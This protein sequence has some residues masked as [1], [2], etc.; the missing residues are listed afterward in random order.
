MG[1]LRAAAEAALM[2]SI[3]ARGSAAEAVS[4][5]LHLKDERGRQDEYYSSEGAGQWFGAGA[6]ALGI[7]GEITPEAFALAA[8]GRSPDGENLV[9]GAGDKHRAG[10]D[11]TLSAPKSVSVLWGI[12]DASR[13]TEIQA[14]HGQ[15]VERALQHIEQ[16]FTLARRGKGGVEREQAKLLWSV[17][18]HGTSREQDPQLHSHA[19][20]HNLAQRADGTWGGIDPRELYQWKLALGA[21][22]RAG[23]A[24]SMR[25]LGYKIE[26]DGD[27]FRVSGVP[28]EVCRQF[29]KRREQIEAA[30]AEAGQSSAKSSE[31]AALGTRQAKSRDL[32]LD[33]LHARWQD[34]ASALH[35]SA[36]QALEVETKDDLGPMPAPEELL[37]RATEHD[38]VIEDRHI[39]QAV[40]VA[41]QHR[42]MGLDAIRTHVEDVLASDACM[43]LVH[44]E[45]GDVRY[46][47]RELYRQERQIISAAQERAE[48]DH[49]AVP[50][51]LVDQA[52][53][54]FSTEKGFALSAEQQTAVRHVTQRDGAVQ[55][56]VGDAGTGKSTAMLAAR[57][58]WESAGQR[59]IGCAISGKAAAGL[60]EGSGIES[61]TIASLLIT[62]EPTTD[63]QTGEVRAPRDAL[64]S[65]DVLVIDEAGMVDSRTMHRLMEHVNAACC[66]VVMAGDHKQL[67]SVGAGGV[68]RHLAERDSARI[69]E[70]HRQ[71][72]GWARDAVR[73]FSRGDAAEAI[74]R[75][76]DRDLV[77]VADDQQTAITQAVDRWAA[78]AAEVGASE[79]LLMAS[80]NAEVAA[81]NT[82]ARARMQAEHRLCNEIEIQVHDRQGR[83]AGK[84]AVA[85]GDRLLAKKNDRATSLKNGDLMTVER[86]EYTP[87][88]VQVIARLDRT[89]ELVRFDPAEYSQLRHGYAVTT[90]AAQGATVDRAVALAGGSMTSRESTYVQMSRMRE[91]AEIIA[92]RQQLRDAAEQIGP[93]EKM[94]E[95]AATVVAE[96]ATDLPPECADSFSECRAWLND[97]ARNELGGVEVDRLAELKDLIEAMGASRQKETTLDYQIAVDR[98]AEQ[99]AEAPTHAAEPV[100]PEPHQAHEHHM[101]MEME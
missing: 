64:S 25:E 89:A 82:A 28:H 1:S 84:L 6:E 22:Y 54:Q 59:V 16:E 98:E 61:R 58:A 68:F 71:R 73:E 65:T 34:E 86:I 15:A 101:T 30:L 35:F 36:D 46:T 13:Q 50:A 97:H 70:I 55:V 66:R 53:E 83:S 88:G 11:L 29:S 39:W 33:E 79:A 67:Q 10:W 96:Q 41:A 76:L 45:T 19:F 14:A 56:I 60:Q 49:H 17:F 8:A 69:T 24:S 37:R 90:H 80:T 20:L 27:S 48:E 99:H 43:R 94:L 44:P 21:T 93:T 9:Q 77:H 32:N 3:S 91:T 62:L 38:A 18:Q 7:A 4:Y 2:L 57:M 100:Q 81:L 42:G 92:T 63:P 95:L 87:S 12:A 52:L 75:F 74:G 31:L 5:Y 26:A 40:A 72:E 51:A 85:E 78:H 47:T 23:L